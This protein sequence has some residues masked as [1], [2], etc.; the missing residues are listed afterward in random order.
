M[1]V[2][3]AR[4]LAHGEDVE[5]VEALA[6]QQQQQSGG[7][8]VTDLDSTSVVEGRNVPSSDSAA[9][10]AETGS[11]SSATGK[12]TGNRYSYRAAIYQEEADH[13]NDVS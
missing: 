8:F 2:L 10:M 6:L 9:E 13:Q 5:M 1:E 4:I 12:S 11:S 7:Q 3:G